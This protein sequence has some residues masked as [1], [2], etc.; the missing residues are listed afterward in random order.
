MINICL[1]AEEHAKIADPFCGSGTTLLEGALLGHNV[2]GCD[3]DSFAVWLT[4]AKLSPTAAL[5][6]DAIAKLEHDPRPLDAIRL[7]AVR[8]AYRRC[9]RVA[10]FE[11]RVSSADEFLRMTRL[12]DAIVTSPP[13]FCTI[14]YV[15]R[16]QLMRRKLGLDDPSGK[17]MG[18][19][20][21]L[22]EYE[23]AVVR[24]CRAMANSLR[25]GG[26]CA[27]VIGNSKSVPSSEWYELHLKSSGLRLFEKLNRPYAA[28]TSEF[29]D[30][31]IL[32][33]EKPDADAYDNRN[34]G[35]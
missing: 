8:L 29:V 35:V 10:D 23:D 18:V 11:V 3:V 32:L 20:Q 9:H 13:Y 25:R 21:T 15:E 31:T 26:R 2:Y 30:E 19:G 12:Y 28:P 33:L 16:H 24:V 14:D 27:V 6:D 34:D 22:E 1:G 5:L 7:E 4:A 17:S